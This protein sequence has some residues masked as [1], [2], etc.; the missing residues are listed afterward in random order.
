[1]PISKMKFFD[2]FFLLIMVG[3]GAITLLGGCTKKE[4]AIRRSADVPSGVDR[5]IWE[6]I[7]RHRK[8]MGLPELRYDAAIAQQAQLHSENMAS[9]AVR[10]GHEGFDERAEAIATVVPFSGISENV[11]W[12][13]DT[14]AIADTAVRLWLASPTHRSNIEGDF[15][16]T[17]IGAAL[18]SDGVWYFAQIFAKQR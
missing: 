8:G 4:L 10:F 5:E 12:C 1:M 15:T 7:N 2:L 11:A 13:S 17:G 16:T 6:R 18:N 9:G 3:I 14:K